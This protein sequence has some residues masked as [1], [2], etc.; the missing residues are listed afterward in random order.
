MIR[1]VSKLDRTKFSVGTEMDETQTLIYLTVT[2]TA[3]MH[4]PTW[5]S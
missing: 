4:H 1:L 5:P 2:R 3:E